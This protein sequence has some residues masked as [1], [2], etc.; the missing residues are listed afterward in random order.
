MDYSHPTPY[1]IGLIGR[2]ALSNDLADPCFSRAYCFIFSWLALQGMFLKVDYPSKKR[3]VI[4]NM[5][6]MCFENRVSWL[7]SQ[8]FNG[9]VGLCSS[10]VC[11]RIQ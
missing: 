3:R 7:F 2:V 4:V 5:C 1:P 8:I 6:I 11:F 9:S 10:L